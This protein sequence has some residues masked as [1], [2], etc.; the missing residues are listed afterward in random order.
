MSPAELAAKA[1]IY[2]QEQHAAGNM[3]STTAAVLHIQETA[4]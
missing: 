4:Q 1:R 3:I 2:Q